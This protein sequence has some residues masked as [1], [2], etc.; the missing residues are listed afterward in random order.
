MKIFI[1]FSEEIAY[2]KY[3]KMKKSKNKKILEATSEVV[4]QKLYEE[5]KPHFKDE[6]DA[7]EWE[8]DHPSKEL[9]NAVKQLDNTCKNHDWSK[10]ESE[11][12]TL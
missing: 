8:L 7:I 3:M 12:Y 11:S 6:W 5:A 9:C 2:I 10:M 4:R 1:Y